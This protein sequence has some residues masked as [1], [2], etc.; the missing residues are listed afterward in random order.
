MTFPIRRELY[1]RHYQPASQGC[2]VQSH[3]RNQA[4]FYETERQNLSA[5]IRII[6]FSKP[7]FPAPAFCLFRWRL[8]TSFGI[9]NQC[10]FLLPKH[11]YRNNFEGR[12][13]KNRFFRFHC[14]VFGY[15]L[16]QN[17]KI[18]RFHPLIA[19][20]GKPAVFSA[21]VCAFL[22]PPLEDRRTSNLLANAKLRVCFFFSFDM[23]FLPV[24][25]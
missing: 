11:R 24:V 16:F 21:S 19:T 18:C 3:C 14:P 25:P 15:D 6:L 9:R 2:P 12:N 22:K 5:G 13:L 17:R 23:L 4:S 7:V 10:S 20:A 8:K 1:A